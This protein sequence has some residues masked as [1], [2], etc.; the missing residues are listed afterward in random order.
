MDKT[1]GQFKEAKNAFDKI[2][3]S[4]IIKTCNQLEIESNFVT[5]IKSIN[6]QPT[7]TIII[8]GERLDT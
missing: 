8:N 6:K 4:L 3:Y 5:R 2:Q 1:T 7:T